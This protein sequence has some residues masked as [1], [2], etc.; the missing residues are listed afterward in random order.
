MINQTRMRHPTFTYLLHTKKGLEATTEFLSNTGIGTN[1][2]LRERPTDTDEDDPED[3]QWN[4][5]GIGWGRL[6][7]PGGEEGKEGEDKTE[8]GLQEI[9]GTKMKM[10]GKRTTNWNSTFKKGAKNQK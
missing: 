2:W 1:R 9:D 4:G 5:L 10:E 7:R 3:A 8:N 6:N